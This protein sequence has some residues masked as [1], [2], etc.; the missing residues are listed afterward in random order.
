MALLWIDGFDAYGATEDENLS[1]SGMLARK[2]LGGVG[3]ESK[4]YVGPGRLNGY[5]LR[6]AWD[7][8]SYFRTPALTADDTL[9]VGF[10]VKFL[11]SYPVNAYFVTLY[12]GATMGSTLRWQSSGEVSLH[13][14]TSNTQLLLSSGAAPGLGVWFYLEMLITCADS[15]YA[16]VRINGNTVLSGTVDTKAGAHNYHDSVRFCGAGTAAMYLMDDLYILD[17][18]G[19]VNNDF[20]GNRRVATIRPD[21][22]GDSTQFMPDSGSNYARVSEE[23]CDTSSYVESDTSGEKDLYNYGSLPAGFTDI[24]GVQ[25]STDCKETDAQTYSLKTVCKA[26]S[27]ESVDAGQTVGSLDLVT[28]RRVLE[29]DPSNNGWTGTAVN[30]AQ[31]GIEVA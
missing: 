13:L 31:F 21:A 15:G 14:G 1:P 24:K 25:I 3:N 28:R 9:V 6:H 23:V 2:Y 19:S 20:L 10:A 27:V 16:E 17:G 5:S 7:S 8:T 18:S 4:L 12:D 22:A 26:D 11:G 29:K 30:A